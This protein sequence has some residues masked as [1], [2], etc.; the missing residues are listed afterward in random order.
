MQTSPQPQSCF[1]S[2]RVRAHTFRIAVVTGH[3]STRMPRAQ[4]L[5]S[6]PTAAWSSGGTCA[7]KRNWSRR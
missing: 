4:I 2:W 1:P 5:F 3:A 7:R 6:V